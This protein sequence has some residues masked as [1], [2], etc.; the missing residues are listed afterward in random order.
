MTT[1]ASKMSHDFIIVF[2]YNKCY[3]TRNL[4]GNHMMLLA[5]AGFNQIPM[6]ST[7]V[8]PHLVVFHWIEFFPVKLKYFVVF[9]CEVKKIENIFLCFPVKLK[10]LVVFSCESEKQTIFR[11]RTIRLSLLENKGQGLV[12]TRCVRKIYF[13]AGDFMPRSC[14]TLK[15]SA[16]RPL[17]VFFSQPFVKTQLTQH[18]SCKTQPNFEK[19]ECGR[20]GEGCFRKASNQL[21]VNT[22]SLVLKSINEH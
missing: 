16:A 20:R 14:A 8:W 2:R 7:G 6:N 21:Q 13:L 15:S 12:L 18:T 1:F 17:F 9:S 5:C 4:F 22:C 19:Q 3:L 11:Q 10:Y